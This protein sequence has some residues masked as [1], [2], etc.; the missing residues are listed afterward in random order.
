[1]EYLSFSSLSSA[2]GQLRTST[3]T[4]SAI[5]SSSFVQPF[6]LLLYQASTILVSIKVF[7]ILKN[8]QIFI[9]TGYK[10]GGSEIGNF[11]ASFTTGH[12]DNMIRQSIL[13]RQALWDRCVQ[14]ALWDWPVRQSLWDN[15]WVCS[16]F[17]PPILD[18]FSWVAVAHPVAFLQNDCNG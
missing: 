3:S 10:K 11:Y 16:Q 15:M 18:I 1:M 5:P 14:Q 2:P 9:C 4:T 12:S 6:V 13:F 17:G 7:K 8:M